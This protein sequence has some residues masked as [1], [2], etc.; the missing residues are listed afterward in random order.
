MGDVGCNWKDGMISHEGGYDRYGNG[1]YYETPEGWEVVTDQDWAG[2]YEFD[3]IVVWKNKETGELWA[4]W[5]SGCSCPTPFADLK[6]PD[7]ALR[8]AEVDDLKSLVE[9]VSEYSWRGWEAEHNPDLKLWESQDPKL[10]EL[11]TAVHRA[12]RS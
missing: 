10:A 12:L 7:G 8:I 5:D 4:A 11:K 1:P 9:Q 2:D 6:L 3:Q